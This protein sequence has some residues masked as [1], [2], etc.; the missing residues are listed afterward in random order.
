MGNDVAAALTLP[1]EVYCIFM[2]FLL[3]MG[4][5]FLS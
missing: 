2:I 5:F 4:R 3:F 1:S